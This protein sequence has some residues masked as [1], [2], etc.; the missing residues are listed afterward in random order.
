[1][2]F[3]ILT[4]VKG[5]SI[6]LIVIMLMKDDGWRE[7]M[8]GTVSLYNK[9]GD[10]MYTRYVAA[11]P[12]YGKDKFTGKFEQNI[13]RIKEKFPNVFTLGLADGARDNWPFLNKHT[14]HQLLDFYHVSEYVG[15]IGKIACSDS[16]E[17]EAWIEDHCH[18]IKHNMGGAS[19]FLTELKN[20]KTAIK[21]KSDKETIN[22][23]ISYFTN[24]DKEDRMQ[25][26]KFVDSP[27]PLGSGY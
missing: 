2:L 22:R 12:E 10:R 4:A 13:E 14:D 25:Y 5:V 7:A 3:L 27:L 20:I 8:T 16:Q 19:R 18:K 17:R 11:P 1:M 23:A 6:I 21:N 9:Y 24:N 15:S 26:Y